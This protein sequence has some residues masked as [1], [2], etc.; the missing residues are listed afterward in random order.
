MNGV[1]QTI[2]TKDGANGK[3]NQLTING[4][5]YG[6]FGK[7]FDATRAFKA[8]DTVD[9]TFTSKGKYNNL[10]SIK[11]VTA[12]APSAPGSNSSG[13]FVTKEQSVL[14]SYAKDLV[15]S[16]PDKFTPSVAVDVVFSMIDDIKKRMSG[17]NPTAQ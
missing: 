8:G 10:E 7:Q 12:A 17:V 15:V 6:A 16:D 9:F 3:F 1:I 11:L 4:T 14:L 2:I 13:E 5:V